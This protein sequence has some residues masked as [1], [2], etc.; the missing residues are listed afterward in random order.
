MIYPDLMPHDDASTDDEESDS[1]ELAD[2]DDRLP[3][4]EE[5]QAAISRVTFDWCETVREAGERYR[6]GAS[7]RVLA[8]ELKVPMEKVRRA[9]K[10]YYL[11]FDEA[12]IDTVRGIVFENGGR[13][14]RDGLDV[15]K[16]DT[17]RRADAEKHVQEFV[18]RTLLNNEL[19]AVD[20]EEPVPKMEVPPFQALESM[21]D[22]QMNGMLESVKESLSIS[23]TFVSERLLGQ[24][25][26]SQ[27]VG[28]MHQAVDEI[29]QQNIRQI[30]QTMQATSIGKNPIAPALASSAALSSVVASSAVAGVDPSIVQAAGQPAAA[31]LRKAVQTMPTM[32]SPTVQQMMAGMSQSA[33]QQISQEMQTISVSPMRQMSD[34]LEQYQSSVFAPFVEQAGSM[35][36]VMGSVGAMGA[37]AAR[38]EVLQGFSEP[39]KP[40]SPVEP[41]PEPGIQDT[42]GDWWLRDRV[43]TQSSDILLVVMPLTANVGARSLSQMY[44]DHQMLI[45]NTGDA[46][47]FLLQI[48]VLVALADN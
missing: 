47:T 32:Y 42:D 13:F 44:P 11:V 39:A 25:V 8:V 15:E 38:P 19:D 24:W 22:S 7:I 40:W 34:L 21:V 2:V 17:E 29:R 37:V 18:G 5:Q 23:G 45:M 48:V 9:V 16:L 43:R 26:Q 1:T 10:T 30:Q 20:I 46:V 3:S 27:T 36:D 35:Y 14:F 12:P 4:E 33:A 28:G 41:E 31:S 6:E